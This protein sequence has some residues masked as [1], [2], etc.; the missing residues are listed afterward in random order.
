MSMESAKAE[1]TSG[2]RVFGIDRT[3]EVG[4]EPDRLE[5]C[6]GVGKRLREFCQESELQT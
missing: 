1:K 6:F 3:E 4:R 5:N 2:G